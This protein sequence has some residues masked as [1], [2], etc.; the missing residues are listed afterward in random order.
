MARTKK[1]ELQGLDTDDSTVPSMVG[2]DVVSLCESVVS[3]DTYTEAA[4]TQY[5]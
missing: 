5:F 2:G 4:S 3:A 1:H